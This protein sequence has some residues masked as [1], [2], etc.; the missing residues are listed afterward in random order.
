MSIATASRTCLQRSKH[1]RKDRW[2]RRGG[3]PKGESP[4][5]YDGHT[6]EGEDRNRSQGETGL[7]L[8][9]ATHAFLVVLFWASPRPSQA[10]HFGEET[11]CT[12]KSSKQPFGIL[13]ASHSDQQGGLWLHGE[14]CPDREL[15]YERRIEG[16]IETCQF[17][18]HRVQRQSGLKW[19]PFK[20]DVE[21]DSP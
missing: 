14:R 1:T 16:E 9:S 10:W 2:N 18:R 19:R 11:N 3:E 5:Q 13:K 4:H 20:L 21:R 8:R 15:V 7:L 6:N 12:R 17:W